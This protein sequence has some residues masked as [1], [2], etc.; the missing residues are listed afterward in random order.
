MNKII[1][2]LLLAVDKFMPEMHLRQ[3]GFPYSAYGPFV[4]NKESIQKLKKQEIQD[5]FIKT[6]QIPL[7]FS[8]KR[9]IEILKIC[10]E[11]QR[12]IN[13]YLIKHLI[14]LSMGG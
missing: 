7:T 11:E 2:K 9:L 10:Q 14:L 13:Y 6:N 3:P 12:L 5:T 8:M 4:K 1:N